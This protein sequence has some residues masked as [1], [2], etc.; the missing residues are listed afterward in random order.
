MD[1]NIERAESNSS[2]EL[3]YSR[4]QLQA[5]KEHLLDLIQQT[6]PENLKEARVVH[7]DF[8]D[9]A[10][11]P[12]KS[13]LNPEDPSKSNAIMIGY[14]DNLPRLGNNEAQLGVAM[15][16]NTPEADEIR[17][18]VKQALAGTGLKIIV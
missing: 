3:D 17:E 13:D 5:T 18:L 10:I 11:F 4:L 14:W 15:L 12:Y 1:Q 8:G 7:K 9:L 6:F 2:L 16:P